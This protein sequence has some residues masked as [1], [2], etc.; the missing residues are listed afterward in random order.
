VDSFKL[1]RFRELNPTTEF[2]QIRKI[3]ETKVR[4]LR[5]RL[6][7]VV[8]FPAEIDNLALTHHLDSLLTPIDGASA[9]TPGFDLAAVAE[10]LGIQP[11]EDV[12]INWYRYDRVDEI[13]FNDLSKFLSWIWYPSAD[14]IEV[15]D[16]ACS[17]ILSIAHTGDIAFVRF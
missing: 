16:D 8:G 1:E 2:P 17:W 5:I 11:L 4:E 10:S 13:K 9:R 14:D 15:F 3:S 6:A 7:R 12:Y